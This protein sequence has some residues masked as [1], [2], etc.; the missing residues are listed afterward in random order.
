MQQ[1]VEKTLDQANKIVEQSG[2]QKEVAGEV[3]ASFHQV[4]H[5]SGSLLEISKLS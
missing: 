2:A 1:L 3:E 5:V 4:N